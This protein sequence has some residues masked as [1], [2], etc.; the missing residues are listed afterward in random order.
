MLRQW[1]A[2]TTSYDRREVLAGSHPSTTGVAV[3]GL[4][5]VFGTLG[6]IP[7]LAAAS[8]FERPWLPMVLALAGGALTTTV[9][10]RRA[11]GVLSNLCTLFDNACYS[12]ALALAACS[13]T[14]GFAIGLAVTYGFLVIAFPARTYTLTPLFALAMALPLAASLAARFPGSA[15]AI[16]LICAYLMMLVWSTW[17]GRRR[18]LLDA[19]EQLTRAVGATSQ[20]ADD[21][22]QTALST[23]LLSLGN[24]LHELRN[25]QTAVRANLSYIA[26]NVELDTQAQEALADALLSQDAEEQLV[27]E[28]VETLKGQSRPALAHFLVDDVLSGVAAQGDVGV[29]L[30]EGPFEIAGS[31]E[32]L[33]GVLGNLIRNARQAGARSIDV[34]ARLAAGGHAIDITIDDDGPGIPEEHWDS[35]FQPFLYTTKA[36]GTGLGLYLCRR[37]VELF[38]GSISVGRGP[39]GG[40]RFEIR[41]PGQ[42]PTVPPPA[43]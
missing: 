19:H 32:H 40:A 3:A 41:L 26:M 29:S 36:T 24:F 23:T 6:Y 15:V 7:A 16:I 25:H 30:P 14:G 42:P 22:V 17:T 37:Y 18:E 33:E 35:L 38:G 10:R 39:R 21:S 12:G 43:P 5:L 28:T 4:L 8:E 34:E 31:A 2:F 11:E 1:R 9:W 27:R 13:T 20:I